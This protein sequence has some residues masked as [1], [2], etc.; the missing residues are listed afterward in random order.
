MKNKIWKKNEFGIGFVN[1]WLENVAVVSTRVAEGPPRCSLKG[2]KKRRCLFIL[3]V[4]F[5]IFATAEARADG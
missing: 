1:I 5:I 3:F 4:E 2:G